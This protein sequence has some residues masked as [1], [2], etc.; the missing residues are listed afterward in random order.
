MTSVSGNPWIIRSKAQPRLRLFCFPYAGGGASIFRLWATA[1]PTDVEV[2]P[3]YLPGR[4]NRL[5]EPLFT[6]M[7]QLIPA[8][9]RALDPY[10]DIPFAFFGYSMGALIS[11]ELARH[12]RR[13]QRQGPIQLFIAADRAPQLPHPGPAL[14]HLPDGEFKRELARFGGTPAAVLEHEELMEVLQ[15]ILRADFTLYETYVYVSE[16]PLDCP[17]IAFGGIDDPMIS[18]QEVAAWNEQTRQA[19]LL[20]RLPGNHFF[21]QSEQNTLLRLLSQELQQAMHR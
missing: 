9:G 14:H 7:E 1:L 5:R 3:V 2:C 13:G 17:I 18:M 10:M 4:E 19:F 6:S 12:L 8:L 20:H 21:L 15:P 11:F 16:A